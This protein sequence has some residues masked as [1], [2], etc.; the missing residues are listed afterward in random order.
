MPNGREAQLPLFPDEARAP[1][2]V[3]ERVPL[4]ALSDGSGAPITARGRGAPL[5]LAVLVESLLS[6]RPEDRNRLSTRLAVTLREFRDGLWPHG[7][8]RR[9]DL[10]RLLEELRQL[11]TRFIPWGGGE[12]YPVISRKLP[13]KGAA[14]DESVYLDL[15]LPPGSSQGTPIDRG[16]LSELRVGLRWDLPGADRGDGA[17]LATGSDKGEAP[18]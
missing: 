16:R 3:L 9:E 11:N 18:P 8:R 15:A 10:P 13:G 5:G 12:W 17:E 14:L 1:L 2:G 7:W 6:L 4:L